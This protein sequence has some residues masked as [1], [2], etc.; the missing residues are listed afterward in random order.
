[1]YFIISNNIISN[2]ENIVQGAT[3]M[4]RQILKGGIG[5]EKDSDLQRNQWSKHDFLSR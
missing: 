3:E 5:H 2:N 4:L 1:M